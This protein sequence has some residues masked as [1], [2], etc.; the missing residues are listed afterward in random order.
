M[1]MKFISDFFC[2]SPKQLVK[3]SFDNE[4]KQE[5]Y[6]SQVSEAAVAPLDGTICYLP[7]YF[8]HNIFQHQKSVLKMLWPSFLIYSR[9][10]LVIEK[11]KIGTKMNC[12]S[13]QSCSEALEL[14]N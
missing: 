2:K 4:S 7:Y 13:Y 8:S 11:G 9:I 6:G 10:F 12:N 3:I 14:N 5:S 1:E